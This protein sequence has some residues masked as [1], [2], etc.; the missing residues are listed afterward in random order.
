M[1]LKRRHKFFYGL[2]NLGYSVVNQ[3]ITNF[4]MFFGTSVLKLSG[5]V[6]GF[7]VALSTI[8]DAITDP[9][10]GYVSDNKKMGALGYRC[11]Y[12][13]IGSVGVAVVNIF[14]W[15]V[16]NSFPNWIKILWVILSLLLNETFCTM[17]STPYSALC[18]D[19]VTEYNDR[20]SIQ[21]YKTVF[22]I[23]GMVLPS[24]M[25]NIFLPSTAEFPQGQL[26]PNGYVKMSVVCS[27]I[28]LVCG[29]VSTFGL[30][31]ISNQK[32]QVG[33]NSKIGLKTV[34]FEFLN[35]LKNPQ[36]KIVIWGY[37]LS[38]V[39]ATILTSVGLHFFTYCFGY[40]SLKITVLLAVL[41]FGMI[42]SQPFWYKISLGRDKKPTLL[43]GLL[44]AIVGV[45]FIMFAYILRW[46]IVKFSFYVVA[47]SIF[48]VG[49]GSGVLYLLPA[50]MYL[51]VT[52][53]ISNA[54]GDNLSAVYQSFLTFAA[55]LTSSIA[56]FFVGAMLDFI[57]F[58][59]EK[60]IQTRFTQT[61]IAVILFLG[62]LVCLVGSFLIFSKYKL[63]EKDFRWSKK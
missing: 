39:S 52:E 11:G 21:I 14:I 53:K 51:D 44:V 9:V 24:I 60:I 2:G 37:S 10:F 46:E 61:G 17:F 12:M 13:L 26:N 38:M 16:P 32:K 30:I 59:P 3:T 43:L 40:E 31:K 19:L 20:T 63:K 27:V 56:L 15:A 49:F 41:L 28:M 54:N 22:F 7:A 36:Q 4:F 35:C 18:S 57:K 34:L 48:I 55:N 58:N 6:I 47:V 25:L 29:L 8:W 62:V 45:V 5:L 33:N 42:T 50:S 1:K 23:L